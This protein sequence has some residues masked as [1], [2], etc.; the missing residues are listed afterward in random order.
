MT[1]R[2][3]ETLLLLNRFRKIVLSRNP[4]TYVSTRN[5]Y[6]NINAEVAKASNGLEGSWAVQVEKNE[7]TMKEY[8]EEREKEKQRE[9]DW[10][11]RNTR[12]SNSACLYHPRGNFSRV[13][14]YFCCDCS[15]ILKLQTQRLELL[16]QSSNYIF[17]S[18]SFTPFQCFF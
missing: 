11:P 5:P 17:L 2:Y 12:S 15:S 9:Y 18:S 7:Q 14:Y 13:H 3:W 8:K 16:L 10:W 1:K 6:D 4:R